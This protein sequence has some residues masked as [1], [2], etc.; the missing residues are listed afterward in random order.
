MLRSRNADGACIQIGAV[1]QHGKQR[2]VRA[3]E[4]FFNVHQLSSVKSLQ[5]QRFNVSCQCE[6]SRHCTYLI[7]TV[8]YTILPVA[9]YEYIGRQTY[10][11]ALSSSLWRRSATGYAR[12]TQERQRRCTV[13]LSESHH[14]ELFYNSLNDV[15]VLARQ[16]IRYCR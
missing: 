15:Q 10:S 12:H 4:L 11:F 13:A 1:L 8:K 9:S 7:A 3:G 14:Q 5:I 2:F 6:S 16:V